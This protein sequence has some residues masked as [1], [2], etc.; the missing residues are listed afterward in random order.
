MAGIVPLCRFW[1]A[2]VAALLLLSRLQSSRP[3]Q[4]GQVVVLLVGVLLWPLGVQQAKLQPPVDIQTG[5]R[6]QQRPQDQRL[7]AS[8]SNSSSNVS[9]SRRRS[10]NHHLCQSV[11]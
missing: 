9:S 4:G 6:Q 8:S 1:P 5:R 7:A 11:H 10:S 3:R 2:V